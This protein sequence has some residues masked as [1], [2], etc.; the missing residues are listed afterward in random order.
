IDLFEYEPTCGSLE[1]L[2]ELQKILDLDPNKDKDLIDKFNNSIID[3]FSS[4]FTEHNMELLKGLPDDK[5]QQI[6]AL[7]YVDKGERSGES[8]FHSL[9][10]HP[11]KKVI[12]QLLEW[13]R[14]LLTAARD[15]GS[16]PLHLL[17][18]G[19][20]EIGWFDDYS[21]TLEFLTT[22]YTRAYINVFNDMEE[23]P[24]CLFCRAISEYDSA[25]FNIKRT[26]PDHLFK[27]YDV[28]IDVNKYIASFLKLGADENRK[29]LVG[30]SPRDYLD[31]FE[32][33]KAQSVLQKNVRTTSIQQVP[34]KEV[35]VATSHQSTTAEI[36]E[37]LV[38]LY[39]KNPSLVAEPETQNRI[40]LIIHWGSSL[41]SIP[42]KTSTEVV[43]SAMD[44]ESSQP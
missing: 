16:T 15:D 19:I 7:K 38:A 9:M 36:L 1:H 3:S 29:S 39:E 24:F 27:E 44:P 4:Y 22:A 42:K 13:D 43:A 8:I 17:G 28:Y 11:N 18:E 25:G 5:R 23:T 6:L 41:F 21:W 31:V 14:G 20:L 35:S 34:K 12:E 33:K 30:K 32:D 10:Y 40:N 26:H 2:F 37:Q